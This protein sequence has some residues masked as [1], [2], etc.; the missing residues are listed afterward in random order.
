MQ[1]AFRAAS[2]NRLVVE[3]VKVTSLLPKKWADA[4]AAKSGFSFIVFIW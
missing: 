2:A 4:V 3:C 1:A